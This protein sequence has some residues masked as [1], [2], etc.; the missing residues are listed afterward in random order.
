MDHKTIMKLVHENNFENHTTI[1]FRYL[2]KSE[3]E[4]ALVNYI[5]KSKQHLSMV[6]RYSKACAATI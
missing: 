5:N 2:K 6:S 3:I 4:P 1:R